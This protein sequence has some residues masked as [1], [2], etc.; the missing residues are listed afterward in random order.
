M[1]QFIHYFLS[2]PGMIIKAMNWGFIS[3][4]GAGLSWLIIVTGFV[5][6]IMYFIQHYFKVNIY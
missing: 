4:L 6:L 3:F 1:E 5:T 2:I